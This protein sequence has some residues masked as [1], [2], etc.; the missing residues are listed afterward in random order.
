MTISQ[1][2]WDVAPE[3]RALTVPLARALDVPH[4]VAH[5]LA[6]RGVKTLDEAEHFLNPSSARID[7]PFR[8]P[9]MAVAVSRIR[10]A[11]DKQERVL[12]F[13]DYDVD[14]IS[15]TAILASTLRQMGFEHCVCGLPSRFLDGYGLSPGRVVAAGESGV[16]LLVTVDNGINARAAAEAAKACGID[17]IVT[18]HHEVEGALPHAVA[19]VNP[20]RLADCNPETRCSGAAVAFKLAWALTGRQE[21]LDLAALGTV[22]D[23]IALKGE[24]RDLVSAGLEQMRRAPRMGLRALADVARIDIEEV[25]AENIMYQLGPRL[26]AA[27]RLGDAMASLDLLL[28]DSAAEAQRLAGELDGHNQERREVEQQI[29]DQAAADAEAM[30]SEGCH[31]IVLARRDWHPGVI[32]IVAAKLAGRFNSPAIL[33]ALDEQGVGRGSARCA[34][35][36]D[37]VGALSACARFLDQFGGHHAAAGMT[38]REENVAPF[39]EA[40]EREAAARLARMDTNRTIAIDGQVALSELG[41]KLIRTLDR[42]QPFGHGNPA[43]IFCSYGVEVLRDSVRELRGGHI[44]FDVRQGGTICSAIGFR[45][46]GLWQ[47]EGTLDVAFAPQLNTW[48]GETSVQLVLKDLRP[49]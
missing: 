26:N 46:A 48:R 20:A 10:R 11:L 1:Y 22:A 5:L 34:A 17:L 3:D 38:I 15:G 29:L 13:G 35:A 27:G 36:F 23:V 16:S 37:M 9:D 28:T 42:M 45:M 32:G 30:V 33:I 12:V 25:T 31:A 4:I 21:H 44:K 6:R 24:N 40:F 2:E 8:L 39:R 43:P 41:G 18:D 14:G 49:A 19:V 47:C 7:D